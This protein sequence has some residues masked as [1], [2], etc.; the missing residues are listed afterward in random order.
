LKC[1][2]ITVAVRVFVS[3]QCPGHTQL[4]PFL[5]TY[6]LT[7]VC[8][9]HMRKQT[10]ILTLIRLVCSVTGQVLNGHAELGGQRVCWP[11]CVSTV[12][13]GVFMLALA[14]DKS[15]GP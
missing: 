5:F 3:W 9:T 14:A 4:A 6:A 12:T 2:R 7:D 8:N 11:S 10:E 13:W 15:A 1:Y